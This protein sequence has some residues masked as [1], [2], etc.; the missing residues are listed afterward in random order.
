MEELVYTTGDP[1]H[2]LDS[3]GSFW[4]HLGSVPHIVLTNLQSCFMTFE[5]YMTK[6]INAQSTV[7]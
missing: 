5:K 3:S 4:A 6:Y 2:I 1:K 7:L